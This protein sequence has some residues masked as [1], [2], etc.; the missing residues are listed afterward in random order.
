VSI[1]LNSIEHVLKKLNKRVE[2]IQSAPRL[3][4]GSVG[5]G[6]QDMQLILVGMEVSAEEL[7]E[8]AANQ[9]DMVID[10]IALGAMPVEVIITGLAFQM[11]AAGSLYQQEK[12]KT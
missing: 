10:Q 7:M 6:L 1:E 12:H 8:V 11:F 5:L 4:G 2:N 9:T 3:Y